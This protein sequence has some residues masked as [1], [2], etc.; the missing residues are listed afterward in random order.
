ML[1]GFQARVQGPQ[2]YAHGVGVHL[3]RLDAV[4]DAP[5]QDL[6]REVACRAPHA[7]DQGACMAGRKH[8]SQNLLANGANHASQPVVADLDVAV[9]ID[10]DVSGFDVEV[11]Y[12]PLM[13]VV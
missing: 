8:V 12:I 3:E 11:S 10:E 4:T 9:L 1:K 5:K 7:C 13:H 2:E 6:R